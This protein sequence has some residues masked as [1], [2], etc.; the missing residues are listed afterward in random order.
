MKVPSYL[1]IITGLSGSGKSYVQSTLEDVGFYCSDNLPVA[2]IEPFLREV[3][4]HEN[5]DRVGIVVDVRQFSRDDGDELL[6]GVNRLVRVSVVI[7]RPGVRIRWRRT[8]RSSKPS[9]RSAR[10]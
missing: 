6:P 1:V 7:R 8:S 9:R 2:L 3:A 5:A 10:R 4:E